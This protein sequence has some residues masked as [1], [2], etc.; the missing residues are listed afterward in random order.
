[1]VLVEAPGFAV[2]NSWQKQKHFRNMASEIT[3]NIFILWYFKIC[4]GRE[5]ISIKTNRHTEK[6][7]HYFVHSQSGFYKWETSS[8]SSHLG[9][10]WLI[11]YYGDYLPQL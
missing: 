7:K 2:Q 11:P 5:L 3:E 10:T 6:N 1:V 8:I 4:M 9:G